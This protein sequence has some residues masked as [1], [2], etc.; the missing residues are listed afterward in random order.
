MYKVDTKE[1][2][3]S[4]S[5]ENVQC[6]ECGQTYKGWHGVAVHAR[7]KHGIPQRETLD[8]FEN[9]YIAKVNRA[10]REAEYEI[11]RQEIINDLLSDGYII[12][13]PRGERV[14]KRGA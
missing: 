12:I 6:P 3:M 14:E 2:G 10:N 13:N 11:L 8:Y 4:G 7:L 5:L 1:R 9:Q